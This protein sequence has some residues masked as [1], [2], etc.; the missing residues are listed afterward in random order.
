VVFFLQSGIT[1]YFASFAAGLL[2]IP[3]HSISMG[4]DVRYEND[5]PYRYRVEGNWEG[6]FNIE[7]KEDQNQLNMMPF[8]SL[9]ETTSFLRGPVVG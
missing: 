6:Y 9:E 1:S 4:L 8:Q 5:H 2:K 3:W 7:I